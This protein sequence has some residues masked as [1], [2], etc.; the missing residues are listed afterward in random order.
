MKSTARS[1]ISEV[2]AF[3]HR[4]SAFDKGIFIRCGRRDMGRYE[5]VRGPYRE[6]LGRY[7]VLGHE[8][9]VKAADG[10]DLANQRTLRSRDRPRL[11]RWA[12]GNHRGGGR[13]GPSPRSCIPGC[14][15]RGRG[16]EPR[17][18]VASGSWRRKVMGPPLPSPDGNAAPPALWPQL[19]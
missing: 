13:G 18:R 6:S 10:T 12:P 19:R 3:D 7:V 17:T 8:G 14:D 16:H 4:N 2:T 9:G 15:D 11:S 1:I 5:K